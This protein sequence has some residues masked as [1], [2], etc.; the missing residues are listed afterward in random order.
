MH[1]N[2]GGL[3]LNINPLEFHESECA[4]LATVKQWL[5]RFMLGVEA[6]VRAKTHLYIIFLL[7]FW[8]FY[9]G[10]WRKKRL[11]DF[12][13]CDLLL[14][15]QVPHLPSTRKSGGSIGR[16]RGGGGTGLWPPKVPK[17][18]TKSTYFWT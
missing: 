15:A 7:R 2:S 3:V 10:T 11:K 17:N 4:Y 16:Y 14:V 8:T 1:E 6:K 13:S 18:G 5:F 12:N 9:C